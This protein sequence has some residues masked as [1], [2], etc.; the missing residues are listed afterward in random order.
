M[1]KTIKNNEVLSSRIFNFRKELV[2]KAW[3]NPNYLKN[4]WG[5]NGFTNTFLEF[6]FRPNGFWKFVMHSSDGKN[7]DNLSQFVEIKENELILLNHISKP[8]FQIKATFEDLEGKTLLNFKMIFP[9]EKDCLKLKAFVT[10]K[11]E[12]NFDRLE[13]EL[14]KIKMN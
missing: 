3:E 13:A 4:W 1:E 5:P 12:E 14:E 2:F 10:E 7:F 9:S 11:N 6:D 8:K